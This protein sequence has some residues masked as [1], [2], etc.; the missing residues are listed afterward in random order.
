M[1]ASVPALASAV[2]YTGF[3][4][5]YPPAS[6]YPAASD[7]TSYPTPNPSPY[8]SPDAPPPQQPYPPVGYPATT[9]LPQPYEKAYPPQPYG[10]V[11]PPHPYGQP[12]PCPPAA[13]S[14]YPPGKIKWSKYKCMNFMILVIALTY[15]CLDFFMQHLILELIHQD[16]IDIAGR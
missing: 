15:L 14:P 9:D 4:P 7:Y 1:P 16:L 13:Q 8:K 6:A 2:P 5:S 11:Y 3:Q 10:Q 12:Y